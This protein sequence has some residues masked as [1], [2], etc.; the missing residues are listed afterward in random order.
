[1]I[2]R[3]DSVG[4]PIYSFDA[5]FY[6][7][8][9][10]RQPGS[11]CSCKTCERQSW[12]RVPDSCALRARGLS[13]RRLYKKGASHN[14]MVPCATGRAFT[15][16]R[17]PKCSTSDRVRS[18]LPQGPDRRVHFRVPACQYVRALEFRNLGAEGSS[19]R[20]RRYVR[21]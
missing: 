21:S 8:R 14:P 3:C 5:D 4:S 18:F 13:E 11:C 12:A 17:L 16:R 19:A 20:D 2:N 6:A 1:M 9:I 15:V 7:A 10:L